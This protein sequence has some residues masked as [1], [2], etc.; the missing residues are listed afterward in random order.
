MKTITLLL[1]LL[2]SFNSFADDLEDAMNAYINGDYKTAFGIYQELAEQGDAIA[3]FTLGWMYHK[4]KGIH[5][6]NRH[7]AFQWYTKAAEQG[8]VDAQFQLGDF[9]YN[10]DVNLQDFK[11]SFHWYT[12]AAEQGHVDA[13]QSI[14]YMYID[15]KGVKKNYVKA[16][17]YLNIASAK[18][19]QRAKTN[20]DIVAKEMTPEQIAEAQKLAREWMKKHQ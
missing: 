18:G 8:Q 16:H 3:Q 17:M 14:G 5:T 6:S 19:R 20:R 15:G 2:I 13:I 7:A 4:G 9:Y 1:A 10:G 11:Q 12:K